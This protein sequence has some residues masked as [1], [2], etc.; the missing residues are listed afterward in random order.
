M[1]RVAGSHSYP[2]VPAPGPPRSRWPGQ[3]RIK[4]E[5]PSTRAAYTTPRYRPPPR[6][7]HS[8]ELKDPAPSHRESP[9]PDLEGSGPESGG[10]NSNPRPATTH[11]VPPT[12]AGKSPQRD[13]MNDRLPAGR[14]GRLETVPGP[15]R[16]ELCR[17]SD[18]QNGRRPGPW[19]RAETGPRS[20]RSGPARPPPAA[21][22]SAPGPPRRP[23]P[24]G[25]PGCGRRSP[26]WS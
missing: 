8:P 5:H 23:T 6:P 13:E 12:P 25:G 22:C 10:T 21:S 16:R 3:A 17:A 19:P 15:E 18:A 4:Q 2:S 1:P 26:K 14:R 24:P 9:L 7:P 20:A 11:R